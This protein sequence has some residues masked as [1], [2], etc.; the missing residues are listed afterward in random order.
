MLSVDASLREAGSP[1]PPANV[2]PF[3]FEL[4]KDV[5]LIGRRS[6]ARAI[7]PEIPMFFDDAVSHRHALLELTPEG[8]L[9]VRDIGSSNGTRLN[10]K[11]L[12]A[13]VDTPLADGDVITLGHWS[14]IAIKVVA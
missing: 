14:R 9:M 6:E 4:T 8:A 12:P 7:F 1:E 13:M 2:G 11:E 10:G 5:T 3:T